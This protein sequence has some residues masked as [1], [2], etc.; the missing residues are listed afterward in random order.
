MLS[1][2]SIVGNTCNKEPDLRQLKASSL[3]FLPTLK[4]KEKK[5]LVWFMVLLN[6]L[7]ICLSSSAFFY[8]LLDSRAAD[9]L[10]VDSSLSLNVLQLLEDCR[11]MEVSLY[12]ISHDTGILDA[13]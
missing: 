1:I 7:E 5:K 8:G 10:P 6:F 9:F 13:I 3:P 2:F 4:L 11:L 12:W